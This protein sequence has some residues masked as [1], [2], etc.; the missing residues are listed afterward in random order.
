M[1][2]FSMNSGLTSLVTPEMKNHNF[3]HFSDE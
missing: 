1:V 3:D 2:N